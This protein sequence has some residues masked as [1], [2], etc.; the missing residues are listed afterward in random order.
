MLTAPLDAQ[1]DAQGALVATLRE[2]HQYFGAKPQV[3]RILR[4]PSGTSVSAFFTEQ[5]NGQPITGLAIVRGI[6]SAPQATVIADFAPR[7]PQNADNLL[8]FAQGGAASAPAS[9]PAKAAPAPDAA[10]PAEPLT[11]TRFPDGSGSIG[12]PA[13]W[14][15]LM[16]QHGAAVLKGPNNELMTLGLY[17]P[18]YNTADPRGY[19]QARMAMGMGRPLPGSYTAF[20]YTADAAKAYVELSAQLARKNGK[21]EP[22]VQIK[23][24]RPVT[25]TDGSHATVLTGVLDFGDGEGPKNF[26]AQVYIPPPSPYGTWAVGVSATQVPVKIGARERNTLN[27]IVASLR[28]NNAVI[29]GQNRAV[30]DRIHAIGAAAKAQAEAAH[31][32]EDQNAAAF[33]AHNDEIDRQSAGFADYQ[34]GNSVVTDENGTHAR[35]TND[36]ADELVR[37]NPQRFQ[38]VPAL[39]LPQGPGLLRA[40]IVSPA[41]GRRS[42]AR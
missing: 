26:N 17:F 7:F 25:A 22:H 4:D 42:G 20:P 27:A 18:I 36:W 12:L 33:E 28:M 16:A 35:V 3:D 41:S 31:A 32:A 2:L 23:T 30:I 6:G 9:A 19:N 40:A 38:V 11:Q 14:R 34:R 37:Q 29:Q 10:P 15:F 5:Q 13:G 8:K 21:P 24:A 1:L 39:G